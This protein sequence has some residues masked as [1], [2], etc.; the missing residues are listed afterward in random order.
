L[1]GEVSPAERRQVEDH[2]ATCLDC[3]A[4]LSEYRAIGRDL[5]G[6]SRPLPPPTL[7]RDVWRAIEARRAQPAWG[8]GLAGLLRVGAIGTVALAAVVLLLIIFPPRTGYA[9]K[10]LQPRPGQTNVPVNTS[11]VIEFSPAV[12]ADTATTKIDLSQNVTGSDV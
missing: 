2:L 4:V 7:H 9:V 6:L 8:P 1:D 12:A 5:R 11:V 10:M 3:A